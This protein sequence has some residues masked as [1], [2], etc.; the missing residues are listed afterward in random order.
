MPVLRLAP[1]LILAACTSGRASPTQTTPPAVA[2]VTIEA[3]R[4]VL[5]LGASMRLVATPR[6]VSGAALPGRRVT[7]TSSDP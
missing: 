3:P 4:T 6:D 2:A 7:W 1:A 5:G